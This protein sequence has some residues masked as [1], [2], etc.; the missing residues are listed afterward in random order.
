VRGDLYCNLVRM[1]RTLR[2]V[3][4]GTAGKLVATGAGVVSEQQIS[5]FRFPCR[6]GGGLLYGGILAE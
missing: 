4:G 6:S 2:D 5:A 3:S 1:W